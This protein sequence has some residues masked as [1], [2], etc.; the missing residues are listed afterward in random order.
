MP[1]QQSDVRSGRQRLILGVSVVVLS[2]MALV[3]CSSA[4][5]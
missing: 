3:G 5:A 2:A 4:A 1:N